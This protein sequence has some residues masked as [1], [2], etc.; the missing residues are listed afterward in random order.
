M[1]AD[2]KLVQTLLE[3]LSARLPHKTGDDLSDVRRDE[4][5]AMS[6]ATLIELSK[7]QIDI[8]IATIVNQLEAIS[9]PYETLAPRN[10]PQLVLL[11][12]TYLVELLADCTAAN[13]DAVEAAY[14]GNRENQTES[15]RH[16]GL[17]SR[18]TRRRERE[19]PPLDEGQAKYTLELL[20]RLTSSPNNDE[21]VPTNNGKSAQAE[22]RSLDGLPKK[23]SDLEKMSYKVIEYLSASNWNLV[24]QTMQTKLKILRTSASDD[25][26][27]S[28]LQFIA[29]MWLNQKKLSMV[30]QEISGS[31]LPLKKASQNM[32]AALL[33]EAIHR[34]IDSHAKD[35]VDLHTSHRRLE[36]GADLLFDFASSLTDSSKRRAIIWPLQTALVLLIPEVFWVADM[37]GEQRG[38][39]IA[40]KVAFLHNLKQALRMPK[41]ADIAA[42]CL[43]T[44]CRAGSLFPTES[45]SALLSVALDIQ[46]DMREEIFKRNAH[47]QNM[48][49]NGMDRDIMI[50]AFVSLARLSVESVVEHLVPRCLNPN[51]PMSF[52]VTVFAAA[53]VL[54]SQSNSEFFTPLYEAI[55]PDLRDYLDSISS[56]RKSGTANGLPLQGTTNEKMR[57]KNIST[58]SIGSI[59]LLYQI[60]ELLKIR[61]LLIYESLAGFRDSEEWD[62][63]ADKSINSILKLFCDEDEFVRNSTV[64][65]AR[66][67][68]SPGS[69]QNA[70]NSE[71][72]RPQVTDV[73]GLFWKA[74]STI[75][76][77]LSKKLLDYD[78]RDP[79]LKD[80][81][82]LV[83]GYLETRVN[84]ISSSKDFTDGIPDIPE[85]AITNVSLEVSFLVLLCSSDLDICSITTHAIALL[86]EEGRLTGNEEDLTR[87]NLTVMRNFRVYS[88]L[89]LQT[90]RIT[91][92]VAFQKRLRRLL[93]RMSM[94]GP[95][96]L[97]AWEAVFIRWRTLCKHILSPGVAVTGK[98]DERLHA[99][100]RNYSG[101]LASI[102]GCC[103]ADLPHQLRVDDSPFVGLRWIDRLASDGDAMSLLERFMKQCLQLLVCKLV[104]V[105]ENIRE[106]L[107]TELNP[108]LYTQLFRSLETEFG[109]VF[110]PSL[111]D[112]QSENRTLFAEQACSLLKTIVERLEDAQDTFLNVD[113]GALTLSLAR[114]L[115]VLKDDYTTLRVKI[116]MCQLVELVAR[117]KDTVNLRQEIRVRN[118]LLQ[119]LSEW[120]SRPSKV[121]SNLAGSAARKDELHRLQRDLDRACLK[122]LVNLLFRLPLQPPESSHDTDV[123]DGKSQMFHTYFTAFLSLLDSSQFDGDKKKEMQIVS[124]AKDDAAS[125]QDLAIQALSNLLSANVDVGLKFSLEIGYHE[126]LEIRT[127]FM[128]VL[129]NILTQGT[130]FGS[131]GDS[132]I[133]EKYERLIDLLVNDLKFALA[134][135]DSCPS[136]EVDEMTIAL[137]NIFDSRGL[138]LTLL[139][140]LIEQEVANTES[141]SEL[142][143]RNCVATKMLS[144]FAKWK[145]SDYLKKVLQKV[146]ERLIVSSDKLDLELDPARTP[147]VEELQKNELQLRYITKV[148][149]DEITKSA[150][151]VPDSF[152]RI[153]ATITTCVTLRFPEAKFTAVGAFIFLR[154]FCPAIVAPDSEGL[155]SSIP[156][157]EMRRGLLLVAKIVQNLANNVLF[158]AKEP[159]MIPLNDFLTQNIYQVTAFLRE[160][161]NPPKTPEPIV[162]QE[163]FDFGSSVALHRFLYDHWETVRQ[164][165]LFQEKTKQGRQNGDKSCADGPSELQQSITRF[166]ALVA[167]LGAPPLDISLGRP[168]ISGSI[169]PAY[170]RY[171]H[172]MLRNSG[173]SVESILSARIVYDSGENKDGMPVICLVLRNIDIAAVD[174]DLLAYCYLKIASRMWHKPFAVLVDA[175]C[176]SLCNEL[177]DEVWRKIDSLMPPEMV[178]NY[179]RLYVYNM[180]SAYRKFFRRTLRHAVK[181]EC[182]AW[183]PKN[184]EFIMLGSL[185]ELQ[186]HF[187]LASLHLPKETMSFLSDSRCVFHHITR[188]SKT[189]GK[190]EVTFKVG[191]QYIQ[192]TPTKKQEIVPGLRMFATVNDIF[193]LTDVEEANASFHT[194]EEN[195]FGIKTENGKVSMFFSS[196]K[197]SEILQTLKSSKSK[198]SKD[199]KPSKLSERTIRPEDVPGTLLNISLMNIASVDQ[200]LRL[201]AY[202]LL[203]ALCQAFR[204]NLDRQF[205]SGRGLSIPADSVTLIVGVS[206]KLATTEPQLTFDFLTEFFVG[207]DKSYAPQRP[208]NI[209]YMAPWLS[210][211]QS[212]VLMAGDDSERGR[213]KLAG[214]ARKII[215]ITVREPRLYTNF[216]QNAWSIISKDE[217]LLDVFLDELIK[218]ALNFGFGSEGAETIGSIASSFGTLTIR[219][220]IIARLRKALNRTSLRPTRHLIDNPV[221]NEICVLLRICL[222]ISFDSRVQAQMFLPELFHIITMTVNCGSLL[223]RSTV[224]SLLVNTVHSMCTSFPLEETRLGRLK[225]IL[226]SLSEPR[227]CLLFSLNRPTSRD[228]MAIQEQRGSDNGT[229]TSMEQITT[230]LLEIIVVA[231]PTTDMAN[232]WRARW[233][234]LVASTAF[235]SN[236]AI[237]PRAFAVMGCLAREDVDD[238]LLYQ[239]L[240]ALRNS[241]T[242]FLDTGDHE[243]LTSIVTGLTKMMDNLAPTSRYL[244]QLFWLAVSIVRLGTGLVF[245]SSAAFLEATL[246]TIAA[247]G[248][249]KDDRM[250]SVLLQG[251]LPVEDAALA[252]DELYDIRFDSKSFHYAIAISLA[253]GLQDPSTKPTALKTL[254]AFVEVVTANAPENV[255]W[256]LNAIMPPYLGMVMARINNIGDAKEI[257]WMVGIQ[258]NDEDPFDLEYWRT[259]QP[260]ETMTEQNLLLIAAL[261]IIDFRSCE[262]SIQKYDHVVENLDEVLNMSQNPI[263]LKETNALM[264]VI[265]A[266]PRFANRGDIKNKFTRY[267]K[268]WG[269][270]GIWTASSVKTTKD[271]ERRCTALTD[272]LIEVQNSHPPLFFSLSVKLTYL[273]SFTDEENS[274]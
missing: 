155:V 242:R 191:S 78:F 165:L 21:H 31:F 50:K 9:R 73:L 102:G 106:V 193:R 261:A 189:K 163:S 5:V 212:Q 183:H 217:G 3:R 110:D 71:K 99:E 85:R 67:L 265:S 185:G 111:K 272:K 202:N 176:Y 180:N 215:D 237:Q 80:M 216:Q 187:N 156:K 225:T 214:I 46:N 145:G 235:Q 19:P 218:A 36:G 113:L 107:G 16:P 200:H 118:N 263:L 30:I 201:A 178:K 267:L 23:A 69:F 44:I 245:N 119:I 219:G 234:G 210:N 38:N 40:K 33:P 51:S 28:G 98:I 175:T 228:A 57:Q 197:R 256:G 271:L 161:S 203:C 238:D 221:W 120:M 236:P 70:I 125:F 26:D 199:S 205:V 190:I 47:N 87:S 115:H 138:G 32:L 29:H 229:A 7:T 65:F 181:D 94:P 252:L 96:I 122:A 167:T 49:D 55:A 86:C 186:Q 116:R 89:S 262:E 54:A 52:K 142:L 247:S 103:I 169:Q 171:Q 198:Y 162:A 232:I 268:D 146:L 126:D 114:Y 90:F 226:V 76:A 207:W 27:A 148:F 129:T 208:L 60:L 269:L 224:H 25:G 91:G 172:F 192:I 160:I 264:S 17:S 158:G 157:K 184:I 149:I 84:I 154:F 24:Y 43:I 251:R 112:T 11:T 239:V 42:S 137:L 64:I 58:E 48:D 248:E 243:M 128:H 249:F 259:M 104:S 246:R 61:P 13:W 255:T 95:G 254:T 22:E 222:A 82:E 59:E 206:E 18:K 231:A 173:R 166:S 10:R 124:L 141:E 1:E 117:K 93:T 273:W 123:V 151:Y 68:L 223:I 45:E 134:L 121:D 143:R 147:S 127:A 270:S 79:S 101:F 204:F 230:L 37:R 35:F 81:L 77:T 196:P 257:L 220:K 132:A 153:C 39:S 75:V 260:M 140:E 62:N 92:P 266:D 240:V 6:R 136:S 174:P 170:S 14:Q 83:H 72:W 188:L 34:W 233:M 211:L 53:A 135:C 253:K 100:W 152:R 213:E 241:L 88:E 20:L 108:R 130:E 168:Q 2:R 274:L 109:I 150:K 63:L 159:Y 250:V 4:V 182:N 179:S 227:C 15:V 195:A 258:L 105:R 133:G 194:D 139:K 41:S 244:L 177:P 164:K 74:T 8:L 56:M 12:Q 144:V 209:L 131:L 66:R 97:M